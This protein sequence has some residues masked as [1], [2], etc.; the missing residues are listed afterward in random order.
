MKKLVP[1]FLA[2]VLCLSLSI[3]AAATT[4]NSNQGGDTGGKTT[5]PRTGCGAAAVLV[6]TAF[7]A[8]GIG[9]VTLKKSK[10]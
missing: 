2:L 6:V 1:L 10:E 4:V 3:S 8:G 5:S 9:A 7:T